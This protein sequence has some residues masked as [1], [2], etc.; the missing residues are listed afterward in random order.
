MDVVRFLA[1]RTRPAALLAFSFLIAC[2]LAAEPAREVGVSYGKYGIFRGQEAVEGGWEVRFAPRRF[3]FLPQSW[4]E[5]APVVGGIATGRGT[6]YAYAGV[7]TDI[8]L[9]GRWVLSPNWGLGLYSFGN[10]R[11]LGGALEFRSGLEV[12]YRLK[13]GDRIG[14]SLYHLSNADL[15]RRNPGSESLVLSYTA[16][17]GRR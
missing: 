8:P 4:P 16:A 10:G 9:E 12:S 15:Y 11:D 6:L 5:I 1:A 13:E 14:L 7:R 17:L 2:P 3:R